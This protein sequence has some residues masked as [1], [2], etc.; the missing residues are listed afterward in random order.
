[1]NNFKDF[2]ANGFI[3]NAA[4]HIPLSRPNIDHG[5]KLNKI[6]S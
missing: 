3:V 4:A 6:V 5:I 2:L 1:M